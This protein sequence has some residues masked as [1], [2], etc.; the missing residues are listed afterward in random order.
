M[1]NLLLC[2][3]V[4]ASFF[5]RPI[6]VTDVWGF[7]GS[8]ANVMVAFTLPCAAYL[9]IRLHLPRRREKQGGPL[10]KKWVAGVLVTLSVVAGLVCTTNNFLLLAAREDQGKEGLGD[11]F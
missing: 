8:T 5:C 4:S 3:D 7:L 6:Q 9:K 2:P 11:R 10:Y 1:R